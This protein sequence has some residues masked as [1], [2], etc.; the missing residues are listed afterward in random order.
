VHIS[1]LTHLCDYNG[2]AHLQAAEATQ[3][4]ATPQPLPEG[5]WSRFCNHL[6][7]PDYR[8][9]LDHA[10]GSGSRFLTELKPSTHQPVCCVPL[11]CISRPQL[12][13]I[14]CCPWLCYTLCKCGT[15]PTSPE[16]HQQQVRM[17]HTF[18]TSSISRSGN[19]CIPDTRFAGIPAI[20]FKLFAVPRRR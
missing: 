1:S 5:F 14:Y 7:P 9:G 4:V 19:S 15:S 2:Q 3:P 12:A 8:G 11:T 10:L 20:F 17:M 13:G 16:P 6:H 18:K